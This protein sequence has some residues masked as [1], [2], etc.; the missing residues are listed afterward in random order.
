[1]RLIAMNK[2]ATDGNENSQRFQVT[3]GEEIA[4]V[5][6]V[7]MKNKIYAVELPGQQA[8]FITKIKDK[9]N[10][11]SWISIPQGNDE[12]AEIVGEVITKRKKD[13][14]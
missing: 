9:N 2:K 1:V 12:L 10:K 4:W 6:I 3:I 14:S 13:G 8:L 7:S 5:E 11:I